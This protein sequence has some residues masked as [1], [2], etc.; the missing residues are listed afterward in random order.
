MFTKGNTIR[1]KGAAAI[2][3]ML[4]KNT[5]IITLDLKSNDIGVEGGCSLFKVLE[6]TNRTLTSIDLSGMSG[7]FR[8]FFNKSDNEVGVN[9]NHIGKPGADAV[10]IALSEN[11]VLKE[12]AVR[13][14][15]FGT[16]GAK[17]IAAGLSTNNTL[18]VLDLG[19]NSI[20]AE[21]ARAIAAALTT[22]EIAHLSLARNA[23]GDIGVHAI[24]ELLV[25][26]KKLVTLDLAANNITA[27]G[28]KQ[29]SDAIR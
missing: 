15:G 23:I 25:G 1:N 19:S 29:L 13:E 4:K 12:L 22:S 14:N 16:D 24:S 10:A 20:G 17:S 9:R 27:A 26:S 28:V 2:A 6:T 18:S 5:T 8:K 3:E 21:G 11:N 7:R